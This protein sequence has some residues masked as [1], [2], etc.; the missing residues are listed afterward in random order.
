MLTLAQQLDEAQA[1]H[2]VFSA[3]RGR[4]SSLSS[5]AVK[6]L[7]RRL[8]KSARFTL[9]DVSQTLGVTQTDAQKLVKLLCSLCRIKPA[10]CVARRRA[11]E[12]SYT[13]A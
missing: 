5:N 13:W 3:A 9:V 6:Y 4:A 10:E 7:Q 11:E 1:A 12:W 8:E 2:E